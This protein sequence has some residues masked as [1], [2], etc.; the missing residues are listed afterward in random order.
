MHF[1]TCKHTKW[2]QKIWWR[3]N[4]CFSD[5]LYFGS[6]DALVYVM[7]KFFHQIIINYYHLSVFMLPLIHWMYVRSGVGVVMLP[8]LIKSRRTSALWGGCDKH[9]SNPMNLTHSLDTTQKSGIKLI[10]RELSVS[11]RGP[12]YNYIILTCPSWPTCTW[13]IWR[14]P[15]KTEITCHEKKDTSCKGTHPEQDAKYAQPMT[16]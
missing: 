5:V 2:C 11:R 13:W 6:H 3:K 15:W 9:S 10:L 16:T 7:L 1:Y 8:F 12:G 4:V 14:F